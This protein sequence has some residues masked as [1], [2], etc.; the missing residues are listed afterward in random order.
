METQRPEAGGLTD[1]AHASD[2]QERLTEPDDG[3]EED[4]EM[5]F[6]QGDETSQAGDVDTSCPVEPPSPPSFYSTSSLASV[7]ASP[8]SI[9]VPLTVPAQHR[10]PRTSLK[11]TLNSRTHRSSN[12]KDASKD[13]LPPSL[14]AQVDSNDAADSKSIRAMRSRLRRHY[15]ASYAAVAST[16]PLAALRARAS[17]TTGAPTAVGHLQHHRLSSSSAKPS[18]ADADER[19]A[20]DSPTQASPRS[21]FSTSSR[22]SPKPRPT[23]LVTP[24]DDGPPTSKPARGR[25][26]TLA[27]PEMASSPAPK[28]NLTLTRTP[29]SNSLEASSVSQEQPQKQPLEA[30]QHPSSE[31]VTA[32]PLIQSVPE[33]TDGASSNP[34]SAQPPSAPSSSDR[35]E[36]SME[37]TPSNKDVP[38]NRS[39]LSSLSMS[40]SAGQMWTSSL[41][42]AGTVP[43][44]RA[45]SKDKPSLTSCSDSQAPHSTS[46]LDDQGD[47][48]EL[49]R[50][51]QSPRMHQ[52]DRLSAVTLDGVVHEHSTSLPDPPTHLGRFRSPNSSLNPADPSTS[53]DAPTALRSLL[54]KMQW[55]STAE[56]CPALVHSTLLS[57]HQAAS[58]GP[59]PTHDVPPDTQHPS[60]LPHQLAPWDEHWSRAVRPEPMETSAAPLDPVPVVHVDQVDSER[61]SESLSWR[62]DVGLAWSRAARTE[63]PGSPASLASLPT[64]GIIPSIVSIPSALPSIRAT[65]VEPTSDPL[66]GTDSKTTRFSGQSHMPQLHPSES[67]VTPAIVLKSSYLDDPS[68]VAPRARSKTSRTSATSMVSTHSSKQATREFGAGFDEADLQPQSSSHGNLLDSDSQALNTDSSH[69]HVSR[70]PSTSVSARE[71]TSPAIP[72]SPWLG[73]N[74]RESPDDPIDES[75]AEHLLDVGLS[76]ARDSATQAHSPSSSASFSSISSSCRSSSSLTYMDGT[77]KLGRR[78]RRR[79]AKVWEPAC[80]QSNQGSNITNQQPP[81]ADDS[82]GTTQPATGT[83]PSTTSVPTYPWKHGQATTIAIN[84]LPSSADDDDALGA[85]PT[86][87]RWGM[88]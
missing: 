52:P 33:T 18:L 6:L 32:P 42:K 79:Q 54:E 58:I 69:T 39:S 77:N 2:L 3:G 10:S 14:P 40:D 57:Y 28:L 78:L 1:T 83:H 73:S 75:D 13:H 65:L 38:H 27:S 31:P 53:A 20:L 41:S 24:C 23:S 21:G 86:R 25:A 29:E 71:A 60:D 45:Q 87:G 4:D 8:A 88:V 50:Q 47:T 72:S 84:G 85:I 9:Q 46:A 11:H 66:T 70:R 61:E 19:V 12:G 56:D 35:S 68:N 82:T 36:D 80:S 7:R 51:S 67:I 49:V 34:A 5:S 44:Y 17:T 37:K 26:T 30:V 22:S 63:I 62:T 59:E 76:P 16:A 43:Q 48:N 64:F 81:E 74:R 15:T 55:Y